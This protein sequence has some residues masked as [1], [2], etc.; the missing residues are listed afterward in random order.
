M[1]NEKALK[2]IKKWETEA[3]EILDR[4][5][6]PDDIVDRRD[7]RMM[8]LALEYIHTIDEKTI[9]KND[10][11]KMLWVLS[12]NLRNSLGKQAIERMFNNEFGEKMVEI[13]TRVRE[14]IK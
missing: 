5:D 11:F 7:H 6:D 14:E 1:L 12:C 2:V 9:L 8:Q 4:A 10:T 3:Q 13:N